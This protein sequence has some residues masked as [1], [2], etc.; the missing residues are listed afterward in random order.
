M[1]TKG[2][3]PAAFALVERVAGSAKYVSDMID[4]GCALVGLVR[5]P[6]PHARI[7]SIDTRK[8]VAQPRVLGV[9]TGDDFAGF[10]LGHGI[11]DQPV[12]AEGRVRYVGE[13]VAAVAAEDT[14][15]LRDAIRAIEVSYEQLPAALDVAEALSLEVPIHEAAPDNVAAQLDVERGDWEATALEVAVWVEGEFSVQPAQ[16]AYMEPYAALARYEPERIVLFAPV[17]APHAVRQ[18]YL[19]FF[20][21]FGQAIEV[22]VPYVGGA[23]G[24]KYEHPIHVICMEF[25]RRLQR[26]TAIVLSRHED[27]IQ[28]TPRV[29]MKIHLRIG[30]SKDGRLLAKESFILANNGAFSLHSPS[31]MGAAT[32]R[33]DNL[34][35]FEAI[36]ANA[37][38]VYTNTVPTQCFRGFGGPQAIFAQ[39]QLVDE[40]AR[41]LDL[42]PFDVRR[43]SSVHQGDVSVHGWRIGS[44][45]L[46]QCLDMLEGAQEADRVNQ[47]DRAVSEEDAS[48]EAEAGRHRTGYGIACGTHV[49]SN[50]AANEE[51]DF[52]TV[53]IR[54][55]EHGRLILYCG[56]VE[57]GAG[58]APTLQGL[59]ARALGVAPSDV[60]VVLGDS[61]RT[62]FGLGSFA[63]RTAF[64]CG[65]ATL[66][67]AQRLKGSIEYLRE[68]LSLPADAPIHLM[69]E[70]AE[71]EGLLDRLDEVGTYVPGGVELTDASWRGNISPA[72][73]FAAHGCKVTVDTWTGR[74]RVLRYWA[75][76]DAGTILN[77]AGA[78]GQ[79]YGGVLQ[80]LGY[81]L[82]ECVVVDPQ[83]SILNPGFSDYRVPTFLDA[84]P[85]DVLFADTYED[86]GPLGAKSIAE[87]PIIPVAACVANAIYDAT[88][89]RV[90]KLPM[91]PETVFRAGAPDAM[92]SVSGG[93][94]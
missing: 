46:D 89:W 52:A 91:E 78:M 18:A 65:N 43:T 41:R 12:L 70:A 25:A 59:A 36:R 85:I 15:A 77:R 64:F 11:L 38:L 17:H 13:P 50:R 74:V 84:V 90:R 6:L 24:A 51:G 94:G 58:T 87:P 8:A 9:L 23:F 2:V 88:G 45:G 37:K 75:A 71:R 82:T 39:E 35:R 20:A 86:A 62:P 76:H 16:H 47:T 60:E 55:S 53:R 61:D 1:M 33:M 40:V 68:E 34:Y 48:S 66:I 63:S 56:E 80:G 5:S 67:A 93:D 19:P 26:D 79:V 83:G 54:V 73:T 30:A 81:A 14:F 7:R 31:V 10:R 21:R 49:I 3:P 28:A 42:S 4:S 69:A 32:V 29:D 72:Y 22:R 57:V 92:S 27:F 44:C